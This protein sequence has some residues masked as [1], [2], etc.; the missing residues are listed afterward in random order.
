MGGAEQ[1]G[2]GGAAI[3]ESGA[4]FEQPGAGS[5]AVMTTVV[6]PGHQLASAADRFTECLPAKA[7]YTYDASYQ[8]GAY[9]VPPCSTIAVT[10]GPFTQRGSWNWLA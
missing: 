8:Q 9:S 7:W 3:R 4:V 6:A 1:A 2:C 5:A 10:A